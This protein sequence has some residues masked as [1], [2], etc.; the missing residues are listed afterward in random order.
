MKI[1]NNNKLNCIKITVRNI[2]DRCVRLLHENTSKLTV[3]TMDNGWRDDDDDD[4]EHR[5]KNHYFLTDG[6]TQN[7]L[8]HLSRRLFCSLKGHLFWGPRTQ[9]EQLIKH[10]VFFL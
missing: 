6:I 10:I 8:V 3:A 1:L 4:D 2:R 9:R 7:E 5:K